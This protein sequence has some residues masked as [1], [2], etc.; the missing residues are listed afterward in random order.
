MEICE[1]QSENGMRHLPSISI[2][3]YVGG[4]TTYLLWAL[5]WVWQLGQ[6]IGIDET[7]KFQLKFF[8]SMKIVGATGLGGLWAWHIRVINLRC[9]QGHYF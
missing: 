6:S 8:G 7:N 1:Q 3:V 2:Y 5:E 4:R 9:V